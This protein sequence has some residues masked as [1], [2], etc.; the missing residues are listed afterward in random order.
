MVQ[1]L[2][3]MFQYI[4]SVE[5]GK[6]FYTLN[7]IRQYNNASVVTFSIDRDMTN[8]EPYFHKHSHFELHVG[9]N[10]MTK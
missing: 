5:E 2:Y 10:Y 4:K 7:S 9:E 8:E 1:D 3:N 6:F